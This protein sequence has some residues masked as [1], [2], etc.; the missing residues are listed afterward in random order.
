MVG[1]THFEIQ[2]GIEIITTQL[3]FSIIRLLTTDTE[4]K[5]VCLLQADRLSSPC[6]C[7]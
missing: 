5:R 1:I 7:P 4:R 2:T 3:Q 6:A